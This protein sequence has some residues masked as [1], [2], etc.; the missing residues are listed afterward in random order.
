MLVP[1]L[2]IT[3]VLSRVEK[4][5]LCAFSISKLTPSIRVKLEFSQTSGA[6]RFVISGASLYKTLIVLE[7]DAKQSDIGF[8]ETVI[9]SCKGFKLTSLATGVYIGSW[10]R[11]SLKLPPPFGV[12]H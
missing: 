4:E 11:G 3:P 5:K 12:V 2:L 10:V 1:L 8:G 9:T 6:V 7:T